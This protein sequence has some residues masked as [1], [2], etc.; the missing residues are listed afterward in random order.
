[1]PAST[2]DDKNID[3]LRE[4]MRTFTQAISGVLTGAVWQRCKVHT[5]RNIL[6]QVPKK[7]QSMVAAITRTLLV[8]PS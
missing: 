5:T 7:Q 3:A 1:M 4:L 8:R 6:S 2:I